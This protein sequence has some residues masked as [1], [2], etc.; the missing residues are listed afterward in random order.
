[1]HSDFARGATKKFLIVRSNLMSYKLIFFSIFSITVLQLSAA[2]HPA[3]DAGFGRVPLSFEANQGQADSQVRFLAR[4]EGQVLY[5]TGREAVIAMGDERGQS[6][7]RMSL[8]GGRPDAEVTGAEELPGK[9]NF[10]I[11]RDP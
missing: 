9:S 4:T 2:T 11:G 6:A 10:L 7:L 8:V 5:L 1:M 3:L